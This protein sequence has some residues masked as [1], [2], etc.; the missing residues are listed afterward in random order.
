[1]PHQLPQACHD[2]QNENRLKNISICRK[3]NACKS[4][5]LNALV[6]DGVPILP[7]AASP[8]TSALTSITWGEVFQAKVEFYGPDD[9]NSI[10]L[11]ASVL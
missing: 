11:E 2:L 9:I 3:S 5:F 6:F 1:L 8:M 10:R 7:K 4:F